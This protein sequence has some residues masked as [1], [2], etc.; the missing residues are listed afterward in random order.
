[1]KELTSGARWLPAVAK[2]SL[3]KR[4]M[5][6]WPDS[7]WIVMRLSVSRKGSRA[8]RCSSSAPQRTACADWLFS[9]ASVRASSGCVACSGPRS[10]RS[11]SSASWRRPGGQAPF[12]CLQQRLLFFQYSRIRLYHPRTYHPAPNIGHFRL[13]PNLYIIKPSGYIIQ[14]SGYTGQFE[15]CERE[16]LR[17]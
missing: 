15:R 4:R 5:L 2:M 9:S 8:Q 13:E 16:H 12:Q 7:C 10:R 14:P 3:V 17:A 1:M 11:A 6:F